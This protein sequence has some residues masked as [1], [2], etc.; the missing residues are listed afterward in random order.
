MTRVYLGW[1][2]L[3]LSIRETAIFAT[4]LGLKYSVAL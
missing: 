3:G 1:R 4:Q 2:Q